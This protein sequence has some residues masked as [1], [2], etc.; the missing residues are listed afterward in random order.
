VRRQFTGQGWITGTLDA[1]VAVSGYGT[2]LAAIISTL[3][4]VAT[5]K[6]RDGA[7]LGLDPKAAQHAAEGWGPAG[8]STPFTDFSAS[9]TVADGIATTGDLKLASPDNTV[10]ASGQVDLLRRAIDLSVQPGPATIKGL[11]G[12]PSI[13]SAAPP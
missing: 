8:A 4:G 1:D 6:V 9:F 13:T 7:L 12:A 5:F 3:K 11:W 2:S 10:E